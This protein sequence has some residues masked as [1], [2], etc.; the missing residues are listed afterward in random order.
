MIDLP[1]PLTPQDCDL[2]NFEFMPLDVMRLR[3]SDIAAVDDAEV[4][5]AAVLAWC[6][7]WHQVPAASLPDDDKAIARL[8]GMGRDAAA[9]GALRAAGALHGFVKCVDG[10]LYHP[11]IAEK[12]ITAWE[13]K[14]KQRNRTAAARNARLSQRQ[15]HKPEPS[16]ATPVTTSVTENVTAS[17][18]EGDREGRDKEKVERAPADAVAEIPD[19]LRR[20]PPPAIVASPKTRAPAKTGTRWGD[21]DRVQDGWLGDAQRACADAGLTTPDLRKEA[22]KFERFWSSKAGKDATKLDWRKTWIN[23]I[24]RAAEDGTKH[25]GTG[26]RKPSAHQN[27]LEGL[28]MLVDEDDR[29]RAQSAGPGQL[30]LPPPGHG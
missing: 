19:F 6:V 26:G 23:W 8:I 24:V 29:R 9:F 25:S 28:A 20:P 10:R 12:A 22:G 17:N 7:A 4:F 27:H 13:A 11:V 3:D 2:R 18:R 16:V 5:R 30:A 15:S 14:D 21:D 1:A